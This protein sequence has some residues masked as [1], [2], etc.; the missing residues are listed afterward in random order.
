YV[1]RTATYLGAKDFQPLAPDLNIELGYLYCSTAIRSEPGDDG[2]HD[3]PRTTSGRPGSRAPHLW[4]DH[5]GKRISTLDLFGRSYV[6]LAG[7]EGGAW[8][9]AAVAAAQPLRLALDC[10]CV[11][12]PSLRDPE[13]RFP[14]A[15]GLAPSGAALVRPDGFIAW[16]ARAIE[17]APDRALV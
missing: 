17:E 15:Y 2:G 3:D 5:G 6:L 4:L 13:G 10:H 12:A 14:E 8:R 7:A 16:R 9:K 11:G 1:T